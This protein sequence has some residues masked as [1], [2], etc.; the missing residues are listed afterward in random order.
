MKVTKKHLQESLTVAQNAL[1]DCTA[2]FVRLTHECDALRQR[3]V[4]LDHELSQ[5]RHNLQ[6]ASELIH[7]SNAALFTLIAKLT[8]A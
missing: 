4:A 1:T 8:G 7:Q 3:N 5:M 2:D 6:Q